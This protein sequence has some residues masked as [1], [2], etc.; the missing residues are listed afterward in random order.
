[1]Q[2]AAIF[3]MDGLLIDSE[4]LWKQAEREVF[5]RV[6][7]TIPPELAEITMGLRTDEVTE[8]WYA[9]KPWTGASLAEVENAVIERVGELIAAQGEPLPGVM[10]VLDFF[11]ERNY[12]IAIASNSPDVLI[13]AVLRKLAIGNYF[14][15]LCSSV[16]ESQGKPHPGVY[17][18]AAARLGVAPERCLVFEDSAPGIRAAKAAQMT[19]IAV[20]APELAGD[21]AFALADLRLES[22]LEWRAA[23]AA[24]LG[25]Y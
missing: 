20:P 6:G 7:V 19:A 25:F 16:H 18:T 4:P 1:M 21:P 14:D 11:T 8:F 10:R 23:H 5:A 24:A 3:D 12:R 13:D 22:L 2:P 17:V 9:R 15:A